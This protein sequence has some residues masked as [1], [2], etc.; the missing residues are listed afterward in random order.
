MTRNMNRSTLLNINAIVNMAA[1][2]AF[3]L[4]GPL[5]MRLFGIPDIPSE[6]V[7]LYWNVAAFGRLFGA[8]MFSFGLL[9][10]SIKRIAETAKF[11]ESA[12]RNIFLALILSNIIL[13]VTAITQQVSAWQSPAGWVL[14][15]YFTGLIAGYS[16]LIV[17]KRQE[18]Y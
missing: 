4:Y 7:L 10:F 9:I 17:R 15:T 13:S 16:F 2:I 6:D 8:T 14:T 1:G 3:T 5:M 11:S 12:W 18:E